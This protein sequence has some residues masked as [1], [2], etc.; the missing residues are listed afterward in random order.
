MSNS[1]KEETLIKYN[2]LLESYEFLGG[3]T[4]KKNTLLP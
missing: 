3:Y 1:Y 2:D 4:Y